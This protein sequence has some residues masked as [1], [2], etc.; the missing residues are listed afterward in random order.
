M[1]TKN[2]FLFLALLFCLCAAGC[3][4]PYAAHLPH[5]PWTPGVTQHVSTKT[6][7]FT[8]EAVTNRNLQGIKGAA[9]LRPGSVPDWGV[10]Y[11]RIV[12][13]IY[14]SDDTGRVID[15]YTLPC[16]PRSVT[17]PVA[18]EVFLDIPSDAGEEKYSLAFGYSQVIRGEDP[19]SAKI[20]RQE[21]AGF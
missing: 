5:T 19:N 21:E 11:E 13:K 7:D 9:T 15:T 3:A 12:L 20:I 18:F 10:W 17:E 2:K 6:L 8:Y 16:L 14:V 1:P 4:R